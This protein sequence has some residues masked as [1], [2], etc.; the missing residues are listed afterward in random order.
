MVDNPAADAQKGFLPKALAEATPQRV[1]DL[2]ADEYLTEGPDA[3][4]NSPM[5]RP[6]GTG[7][8]FLGAMPIRKRPLQTPGFDAAPGTLSPGDSRLTSTLGDALNT[9]LEG[10]T[11][12]RYYTI[13]GVPVVTLSYSDEVLQASKL[14]RATT[15]VVLYPNRRGMHRMLGEEETTRL[16][17]RQSSP[18][19]MENAPDLREVYPDWLGDNR[20]DR[21]R[22]GRQ[23]RLTQG[24]T[25]LTPA[26]DFDL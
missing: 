14:N 1:L 26:S 18:E 17:E 24:A 5:G 23:G 12:A 11:I 10:R 4:F 16:A 6:E 25:P 8:G 3:L 7:S 22:R 9:P 21:V 19:Y 13:D 20:L 2:K 15:D